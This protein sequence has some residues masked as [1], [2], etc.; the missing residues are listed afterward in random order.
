MNINTKAMFNIT[1]VL[2]PRLKNGSSIVNLS[3]LAG[4]RAFPNHI[5]YH[6]SK[7]GV[8]ALTRGLSLEFGPRNIRVNS[9]NV[10]II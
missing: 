4:M 6:I 9:V 10:I 2:S 1:Q 3:S 5:L 7:S 8:D